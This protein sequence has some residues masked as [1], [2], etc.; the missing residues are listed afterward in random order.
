[1]TFRDY[2]AFDEELYKNDVRAI[3]WNAIHRKCN[4]LHEFTRKLLM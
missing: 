4:N 1:M 3:D 2:G